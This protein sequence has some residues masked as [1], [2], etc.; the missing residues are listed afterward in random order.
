MSKSY[1]ILAAGFAV[2]IAVGFLKEKIN[3]KFSRAKKSYQYERK[4]SIL[5]PA[6]R[7]CFNALLAVVGNEYYIF[8]QVHLSALVNQKYAAQN[9]NAA[10]WHINGKSV[11][12]VLCDKA[13]VSRL[14]IELDDRSHERPDRQERDAE[15]ERILKGAGIPLLRL[16]NH[17]IINIEELSQKVK[18][19]LVA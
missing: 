16:E 1:I 15:V 7:E 2:V 6:E 4:D 17:G 5:T 12:F 18:T 3:G 11:D 9:R 19:A 8:A 10:F 13:G 14:A